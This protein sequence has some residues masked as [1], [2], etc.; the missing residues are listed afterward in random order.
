MPSYQISESDLQLIAN[1]ERKNAV[2][3]Y[4]VASF[5]HSSRRAYASDLRHFLAWGGSVPS[6]PEQVAAYLAV[7]AETLK[8]ATLKRRVI[9]IGLA[10]TT[11]Q[12]ENPCTSEVVRMTLRGIWR[13]HGTA[14]AQVTPAVREDILAMV[15]GLSGHKG[16]RDRALLLLGFASA[17]RRSELVGL[18]CADV[19]FVERGL[20][21]HLRRSKTDQE[22]AG[23]K[24]AVPFARGTACP[25]KALREWLSTS[26]ITEGPIFRPINRHGTIASS[27]LSGHAVAQI[28]KARAAAAG[29][30]PER[31]SGHSLRAGLITSAA[32]AGASI[33][34]IR[35]QSGHRTDA[36]VARYVR[37]ADLFTNNAA[38]AVL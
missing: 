10:H 22:G 2:E 34:K 16:T 4:F 21:V 15:R 12:I 30:D 20:I 18:N 3:R 13:V 26:A 25:V 5:A 17:L 9:S 29:L 23:R 8:A 19:E 7:H 33:W 31:Y 27:R 37:D 6:S 32:A 24:I 38:G 35:A 14:Q 11:Q 36:M 1:V 28:V